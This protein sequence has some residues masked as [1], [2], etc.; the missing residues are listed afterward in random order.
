M[1]H[2]IISF[3]N[4]SIQFM[5]NMKKFMKI[6]WGRMFLWNQNEPVPLAHAHFG[7]KQYKE[8][9]DCTY[10]PNEVEVYGIVVVV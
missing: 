5:Q 6:F 2:S 7:T 1:K 4:Q 3:L 10:I 8:K 9:R